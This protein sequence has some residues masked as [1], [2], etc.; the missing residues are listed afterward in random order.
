MK[1]KY[2]V[3]VTAVV[4]SF[5]IATPGVNAYQKKDD[6]KVDK[7]NPQHD[8]DVQQGYDKNQTEHRQNNSEQYTVHKSGD[9]GGGSPTYSTGG[10]NPNP[11]KPKEKKEPEKKEPKK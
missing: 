2:L 5:L 9:G 3:I 10:L 1:F 11:E 7:N 8:P 6:Q 4:A